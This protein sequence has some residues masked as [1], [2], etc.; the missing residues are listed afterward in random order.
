MQHLQRW[1]QVFLSHR[2]LPLDPG[3]ESVGQFFKGTRVLAFD[4]APPPH[5]VHQVLQLLA[6]LLQLQVKY[7]QL[8]HKLATHLWKES[9]KEVWHLLATRHTHTTL[10]PYMLTTGQNQGELLV[11]YITFDLCLIVNQSNAFSPEFYMRSHFFFKGEGVGNLGK[12]NENIEQ[13]P[14]S[15]FLCTA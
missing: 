8:V 6:L 11:N 3:G 14:L 9:H 5:V 10:G 4:L 13:Q 7:L 1:L 15:P 2:V 12:R